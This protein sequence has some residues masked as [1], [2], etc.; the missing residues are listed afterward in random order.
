MGKDASN[1][2]EEVELLSM[3][4]DKITVPEETCQKESIGKIWI[5]HY[6]ERI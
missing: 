5:G 3:E 1:G 6:K 4:K 2:Q